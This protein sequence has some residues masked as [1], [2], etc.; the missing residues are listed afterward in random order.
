MARQVNARQVAADRFRPATSRTTA[1]TTSGPLPRRPDS[2]HDT[3]LARSTD[4]VGPRLAR[5][6]YNLISS[7]VR[8]HQYPAIAQL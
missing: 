5:R 3:N 6:T 2:P 7:L 1:S 8:P 4:F